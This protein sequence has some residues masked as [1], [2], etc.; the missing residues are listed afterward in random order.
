MS[1]TENHWSE[2]RQ[3]ET[4]IARYMIALGLDWQDEAAMTQLATECK[5]FGPDNA[6]AAFASKDQQRINKA[7]LFGLVSTMIQTMK[8]AALDERDVHGGEIWKAF[9]KH[10][11]V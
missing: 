11:Y 4:E 6:R 10:L 1:Q 8:S 7:Q 5:V 2:V 3:I 9:A